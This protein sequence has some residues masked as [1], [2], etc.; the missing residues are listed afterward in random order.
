MDA[1]FYGAVAL[2]VSVFAVF[3]ASGAFRGD[4]API[5]SWHSFILGKGNWMVWH[6]MLLASLAAFGVGLVIAALA[7]AD[8]IAVAMFVLML[9][10]GIL[11]VMT[12][13]DGVLWS[14]TL[15]DSWAARYLAGPM[16]VLVAWVAM[17]ALFLAFSMVLSYFVSGGWAGPLG[18]ATLATGI[19]VL[20]LFALHA[21][22]HAG[23]A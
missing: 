10:L 7:S 1:T 11:L 6:A 9:S 22:H 8:E 16:L 15:F 5:T 17:I 19:V 18:A 4:G 13:V 3:F 2:L 23:A 12:L 21:Y 14:T 20:N